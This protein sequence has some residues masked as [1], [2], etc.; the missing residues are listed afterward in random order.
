[1]IE[2]II[3]SICFAA[4]SLWLSYWACHRTGD[5][6]KLLEEIHRRLDNIERE[7]LDKENKKSRTMWD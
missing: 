1:M 6:C 4:L 7:M 5:T 2:A 3:G